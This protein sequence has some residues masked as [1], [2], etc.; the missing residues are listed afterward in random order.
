MRYL[1][2]LLFALVVS[3]SVSCVSFA[4]DDGILAGATV[5]D[6]PFSPD[7]I[8]DRVFWFDAD[9]T[10]TITKNGSDQ[11]SAWADKSGAGILTSLTQSTDANK[12]VWTASLKNGRAGLVFTRASNH[13]L[14]TDTALSPTPLVVFVAMKVL[15]TSTGSIFGL[16]ASGGSD[17]AQGMVHATTPNLRIYSNATGTGN[18]SATAIATGDYLIVGMRWTASNARAIWRNGGAKASHTTSI[19]P[20][21]NRTAIGR[22]MNSSPGSA[23]S[24]EI[25]EAMGWQRNLS[26]GEIDHIEKWF[27]IRYDIPVS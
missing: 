21:V 2:A 15:S 5:D 9:D 14:Y 6:A 4:Q 20:T 7:D 26:Q 25:Y 16:F 24:A 10:A 8:P 27:S 22:Q 1:F 18:S 13:V 11:V 23:I 19:S 3:V 17:L 12:P